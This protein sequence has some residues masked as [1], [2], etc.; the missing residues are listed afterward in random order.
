MKSGVHKWKFRV[1][2]HDHNLCFGVVSAGTE[3]VIGKYIGHGQDA[4]WSFCSYGYKYSHGQHQIMPK[5]LDVTTNSIVEMVLSLSGGGQNRL[6]AAVDGGDLVTI[7]EGREIEDDGSGI[8]PAA[9]LHQA[10]SIRFLG[11]D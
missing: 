11:F 7:F 8:V 10:S 4:G 2:K 9:T 3:I 1:E 6:E 5:N